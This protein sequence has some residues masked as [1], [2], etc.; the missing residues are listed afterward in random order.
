MSVP[1]DRKQLE[2][3]TRVNRVIE[4][5]LLKLRR[6]LAVLECLRIAS[7]YSDELD[8]SS[9]AAL[10][11]A[12]IEKAVDKLDFPSPRT[13]PPEEDDSA[14]AKQGFREHPFNT[15]RVYRLAWIDAQGV[16]EEDHEPFNT[17][18]ALR[19]ASEPRNAERRA[20][21]EP[22]FTEITVSFA[23]GRMPLGGS[24]SHG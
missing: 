23:V 6:A 16:V 5:Q 10:A 3:P 2:V 22:P 9:V 18:T 7:M 13:I 14:A 4:R 1:A 11:V 15:P 8:V 24:S 21:G 17:L 19:E 20:R 12:L